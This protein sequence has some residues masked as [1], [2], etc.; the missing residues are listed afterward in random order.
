MEYH[1]KTTLVYTFCPS[2]WKPHSIQ[3]DGFFLNQ[4]NLLLSILFSQVLSF[5]TKTHITEAG[6]RLLVPGPPLKICLVCETPY[7]LP[8]GWSMW[9]RDNL[10][11]IE[12]V[13]DEKSFHKT[14]VFKL[15]SSNDPSNLDAI[16]YSVLCFIVF[17][18]AVEARNLNSHSWKE[19]VYF[20]CNVVTQHWR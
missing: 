15:H 6:P 1:K 16:N 8:W 4:C 12:V 7:R 14:N 9:V 20:S 19:L 18:L 17:I 11:P 3:P 2:S 10:A 13:H 5:Q